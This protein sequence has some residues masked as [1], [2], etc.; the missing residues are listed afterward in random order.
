VTVDLE[1]R[2]G[3]NATGTDAVTITGCEGTYFADVDGDGFG[4]AL[5]PIVSCEEPANAAENADDCDDSDPAVSPAATEV[6]GNAKDDDCDGDLEEGCVGS[7]CG[8]D[9]DVIADASYFQTAGI[10]RSTDR[11][12]STG[13]YV[14]DIEFQATA[15]QELAVHV[16][17]EELDGAVQLL[18]QDCEVYDEASDGARDT[19]AFLQFRIPS[20]GIWTIVV[21][22]D[23]PGALGRYV[24]EVLND[25][26]A[27][28][29]N[30]ALQTATM[31]MLTAPYADV[32][33]G[34]ISTSDQEW[35]IDAVGGTG[36]Y[37]D[38]VEF[39]SF[40]GDTVTLLDQSTQINAI[41]NL[42]DPT[43]GLVVYDTD[44]G[45]GTDAKIVSAID[46][47]GIY[48]ATPWAE[49]SNSTGS[50]TLSGEATW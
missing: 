50:Y 29:A 46:R 42:Y 40:Y 5:A 32:Y 45:G 18:D 9:T 14:D 17:S 48:T 20:D 15:G 44:S 25:S 1:A 26:V 35:P 37:F 10:L 8:D 36:F 12:D 41:V 49:F 33:N 47:T 23:T 39:Y 34:N 4:D 28:G 3:A 13:S 7:N 31:D 24:L 43:C 21:R 11:T 2:D 19:N 38:D 16:W 22:S 27:L 6:C 30:C